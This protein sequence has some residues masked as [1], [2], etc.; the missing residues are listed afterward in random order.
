MAQEDIEL[1]FKDLGARLSCGIIVKLGASQL[2]AYVTA[3]NIST[4]KIYYEICNT[5]HCP[6]FDTD[7]KNI[8]LYLRPMSSMTE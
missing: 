4:R 1:L 7:I 5:E 3:L 6:L 2:D 8:K